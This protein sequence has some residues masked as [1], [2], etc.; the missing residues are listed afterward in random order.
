MRRLGTKRQLGRFA[1]DTNGVAAIEAGFLFPLLVLV[2]CG[3]IDT[4]VALLVNQKMITSCQTV[5]DILAREAEVSDATLQDAF[6]AGRMS[7]MPYP[8]EGLGAHIAGIQ[9]VGAGAVPTVI[10]EDTINMDP[11]ADVLVRAA[12]LGRQDDGVLAVTVRYVHRPFFTETFVG[13]VVMQ[14]VSYARPRR[15]VFI[16]RVRG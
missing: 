10:W 6:I 15:G 5:A 13:D 7:L 2:L 1:R 3:G 12:G 14:E 9:Y 8:Q 11:N 4:G 16:T